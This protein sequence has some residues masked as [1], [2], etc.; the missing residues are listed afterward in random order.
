MNQINSSLKYLN[1]AN[2]R[3][4]A[5]ALRNSVLRPFVK[6]LTAKGGSLLKRTVAYLFHQCFGYSLVIV[7]IKII[8][9][10]V[11]HSESVDVHG[12]TSLL[13]QPK[14]VPLKEDQ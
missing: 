4:L 12:V 3:C 11:N 5:T 7:I 6:P 8:F 9:L 1:A 13:T 14:A 10:K 2:G